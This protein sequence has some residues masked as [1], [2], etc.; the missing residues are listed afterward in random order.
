MEP[1]LI[2]NKQ[3]WATSWTVMQGGI[4]LGKIFRLGRFRFTAHAL[5]TVIRKPLYQEEIQLESDSGDEHP[6]F[7]SK[8]Q[9]IDAIVKVARPILTGSV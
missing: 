7:R 8:Q 5:R 3:P 6:K 9:A 2:P 4:P 1:T